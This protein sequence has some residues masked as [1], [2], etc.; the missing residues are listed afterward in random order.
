VLF[1]DGLS[2]SFSENRATCHKTLQTEIVQFPKMSKM[3]KGRRPLY[4]TSRL[5]SG[6]VCVTV[7]YD[8]AHQCMSEFSRRLE[9]I[10]KSEFIEKVIERVQSRFYSMSE[11]KN[12]LYV[13][14]A[15]E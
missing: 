12:Q 5:F 7:G 14:L 9:H 3:F 10:Q 6:F 2:I 15:M 4:F 11:T 1:E 13:G 8:L